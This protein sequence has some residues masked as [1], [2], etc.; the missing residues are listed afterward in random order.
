M[1]NEEIS[2]YSARALQLVISIFFTFFI[3]LLTYVIIVKNP[4]LEGIV[5]ILFCSGC[6]WLFI[7]QA[8]S[9]ADITVVNDII[10]IKKITK[11]SDYKLTDIKTIDRALLPYTFYIEF[12]STYKVYFVN[13]S[14]ID[15][16]KT[17]KE[18]RNKLHCE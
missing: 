16:Q 3:G 7:F 6:A 14:H 5:F 8:M 10:R 1:T 4:S 2:T 11:S 15:T 13:T 18:L 9:Y 17:V 12:E